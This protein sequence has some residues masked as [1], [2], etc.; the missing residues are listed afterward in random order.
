[1]PEYIIGLFLLSMNSK[2]STSDTRLRRNAVVCH[3]SPVL[4]SDLPSRM[5]QEG[6]KPVTTCTDIL[7][8]LNITSING[9]DFSEVKQQGELALGAVGDL[10]DDGSEE[11]VLLGHLSHAP[12]H[13]DE[14][15]RR[16]GLAIASVNRMLTLLE[17]KG[18]VNRSAVCTTLDQAR[19]ER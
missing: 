2:L 9:V 16:A 6:A 3:F 17:L 8:E 18:M 14:I 12:V 11:A 13:I 1:M 4:E 7:E 5:I 15:G 10:E 19:W